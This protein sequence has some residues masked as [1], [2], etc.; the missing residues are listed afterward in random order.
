MNEDTTKEM[1][2]SDDRIIAAINALRFEM[3]DE[4][5]TLRVEM[6]NEFVMIHREIDATR[7][8]LDSRLSVLEEKVDR[9]ETKVDNLDERVSR[10]ETKVDNLDE[11]V[12]S[13]LRE[14][15]TI[16]QNVLAKLEVMNTKFDVIGAELLD[17]RGETMTLKRKLPP[18]A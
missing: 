18:A 5:N 12:D 16:W 3:K 8:A 4:I 15:Q 6:Q 7:Q 11:K 10:L 17:L 1:P 13:R 9:M 14:T 2:S